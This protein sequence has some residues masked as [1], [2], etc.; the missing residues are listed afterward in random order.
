MRNGRPG[1]LLLG[2]TLNV[3]GT[4]RQFVRV[5]RGLDTTR[6]DV[7]VACL[8]AEGPLR[9]EL[10]EAAIK[11][12]SCGHG[13]LKPQKS[14]ATILGLVRY[15]RR[16]HIS[17]VHS[18]DF[19][20]NLVG[21]PAAR[22]AGSAAIA[23]QRNLG[24]LRPKTQRWLHLRILRG[25][26]RVVVNSRAIV[27][28]LKGVL[29]DRIVVIPNGVDARPFRSERPRPPVASVFGTVANLHPYKG[30]G[31]LVQATAIVRRRHPQ[32]RVVV[33]GEGR[34]RRELE[35]MIDELGLRGTVQLRGF[36]SDVAAALRECDAFVLPSRS[37]GCSNALLEAMASGLPVIA[38]NV[39]GNGEIVADEGVGLLV[40]AGDAEALAGAMSRLIEDPALAQRLATGGASRV[41]A[42]FSVEGMIERMETTY[43]RALAPPVA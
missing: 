37:E 26:T 9:S 6:W 5:A 20:S 35:S 7:H 17:L 21:V 14:V 16:H 39:G 34:A 29:P 8:R 15:L 19:Y 3:G 13:S 18:F 40:P 11:V 24:D 38:S 4:E 32:V 1:V 31:D 28:R 25:A 36:T 10:E 12:W 27:E 23:S 30:L 43:R 33:W 2:D 41:R 42:D 22:L